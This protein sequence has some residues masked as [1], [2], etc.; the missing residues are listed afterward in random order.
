MACVSITEILLFVFVLAASL[1][2]N[3]VFYP[4]P[5]IYVLI[6][7]GR[8]PILVTLYRWS[9]WALETFLLYIQLWSHLLENV[10]CPQ[11]PLLLVLL[12]RICSQNALLTCANPWLNLRQ[13]ISDEIKAEFN[14]VLFLI[15]SF[16]FFWR[17]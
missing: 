1:K 8:W 7:V 11:F 12:S 14:V 6:K 10:L 17:P 5:Y 9:Y 16:F 2:C 3:V 13:F 15:Y 4:K